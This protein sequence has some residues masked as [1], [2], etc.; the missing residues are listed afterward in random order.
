MRWHGYAYE[1][2]SAENDA[3]AFGQTIVAHALSAVMGASD[4]PPVVVL[5]HGSDLV[6]QYISEEFDGKVQFAL[7]AE[8]LGTGHAVM[9]AEALLSEKLSLFWSLCRYAL[10]R[11]ETIS[12]LIKFHQE[13]DNILTMTSV[14]GDVPRGFGRV[15]RDSDKN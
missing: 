3:P 7:Q 2:A 14:V 10:I 13:N 4:L 6:R 12:N 5:G 11:K 1:I 8:Q 9:S 15:L